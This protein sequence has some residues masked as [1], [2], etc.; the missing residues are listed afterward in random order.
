MM[1]PTIQQ[2]DDDALQRFRVKLADGNAVEAVHEIGERVVRQ[3][4]QEHELYDAGLCS[5]LPLSVFGFDARNG[6]VDCGC[7]WLLWASNGDAN[8]S[9]FGV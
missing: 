7:H 4:V 8:A 6:A 3:A 1:M 5:G 9:G 2:P